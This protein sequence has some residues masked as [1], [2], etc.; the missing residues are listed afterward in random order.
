MA[1]AILNGMRTIAKEKRQALLGYSN[2]KTVHGVELGYL[3]CILY[4]DPKSNRAKL[5]PYSSDA[6]FDACLVSA[7]RGVMTPVKVAREQKTANFFANRKAFIEQLKEEIAYYSRRAER[8]GLKLAVRLNGTSDILWEKLSD[9]IQSFPEIQFYDYTKVPLQYRG[10]LSN[11]H[12]TFS[13]SGTNWQ[14]CENAIAQGVNVAVVFSGEL[15]T[16]YRGRKVIDGT[17]HDVRFLDESSVIVGLCTK[18]NHAKKLKS[19]FI[20]S[21]Y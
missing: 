4:L 10:K 5:C 7:G 17:V 1:L 3:T 18:G 8:K 19:D 14:D 12:L 9:I 13:Y 20:V 6:C 11:Y 21:D 15:P 16:T 2:A